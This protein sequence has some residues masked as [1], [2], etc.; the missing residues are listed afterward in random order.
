MSMLT[1]MPEPQQPTKAERRDAARAR[2]LEAERTAAAA[3]ARRR[4]LLQ[5]GGV[6]ALAAVIIVVAVLVSS[7]GGSDKGAGSGGALAGVAEASTS[8]QGIPQHGLTLGRADAPVTMVEFV[9]PQCPFCRK[10]TVDQAPTFIKDYVRTGKVKVELRTL[11]FIGDDSITGARLI[12]AAA[13]QNKAWNVAEILY[14]NQGEENT[15]WLTADLR[16]RVLQAV[17][18]L[19]V[20]KVLAA[21]DTGVVG[22]ALAT[23][24]TAASRYGADATP[25][26]ALG[27]TGGD[28]KLSSAE[29]TAA[30]LGK[31][32]D[33]LLGQGSGT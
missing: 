27:K 26:F 24:T 22:E 1:P 7:G 33:A 12:N 16:R 10:F 11:S 18:G 14:H 23:A 4:R 19:N 9:D 25:A 13:Q 30:A 2:R 32:V 15:G 6:L 5:L 31:A 20:Q 8:L 29:P 17:P 28:L 21:A 3:G